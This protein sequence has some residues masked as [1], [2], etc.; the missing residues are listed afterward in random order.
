MIHFLDTSSLRLLEGYYPSRFPS[1]WTRF[2][3]STG[4]GDIASVEEVLK[5]VNNGAAAQHLFDWID[6]NKEFFQAPDGTVLEFVQT[7]FGVPKFQEVVGMKQLLK[8]SPVADPFIIAAAQV[9]RGCV[10]TQE[11]PKPNSAKIPTI[12]QHFGVH[13]CDLEAMMTRL[14]WK[15]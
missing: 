13:C 2:D 5:E 14:K 3:A 15:F 6:S 11:R 7:I 1:F 12:C 9:V 10:V 8:G 4:N